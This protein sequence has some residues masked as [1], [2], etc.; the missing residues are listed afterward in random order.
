MI[1][2]LLSL[3]RRLPWEVSL[4]R[5]SGVVFVGNA[6]ARALGFL[7]YV[8][9]ARL[10][11][12]SDYGTLAYALAILST[13][14][15]LLTNA[16]GGLARFLARNSGN[17]ARQELYYSNW[18][19]AVAIVG[20]FL[21]LVGPHEFGH[22]AV[23]KLFKVGVYEFSLGLGKRLWSITRGGTRPGRNGHGL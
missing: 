21:L 23:A 6:S 5:S 2:S 18:V 20:M 7:F 9:A 14:A 3:L 16:P 10:L 8:V 4:L 11:Q 22:F 13:A 17:P 1:D 19:G 15:I 12:P